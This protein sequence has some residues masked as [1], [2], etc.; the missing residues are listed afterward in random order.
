VSR[1][2]LIL[3]LAGALALAPAAASAETRIT[4]TPPPGFA[5]AVEAI[6]AKGAPGVT[7]VVMKDGRQLYRVD[8]GDIAPDAELPVASASKWM[9]AA[10][11]MSLVDDGHLAL[12]EP[13]GKRLPQFQGAAGTITL[14]QLLAQTGGMGSIVSNGLDLRQGARMTLAESAAQAAARPLEDPPGTIFKYGGPGFQVVGALAEAATGQ[15]WAD[16]FAARIARPLGLT[17]TRWTSLREPQV[18]AAETTNPL[19]QGGVVTSASDY[20]KFLTMLAG[21]G[22]FEGRQVLSRTAVEEMERLQ[23]GG[24]KMAWLPPGVD[25]GGRGIGYALGNWCEAW[26]ADGRCTLVSSPGAFGTYPWIDRKSGLYGIF[27]E[28]HRLPKVATEVK[29]ARALAM[30]A[31]RP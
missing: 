2:F 10:V 18:P 25:G 31:A 16:L 22:R 24:A 5:A 6:V 30:G 27:F 19:L 12:D 8:A 7:A 17:H 13:I 14:R 23:T 29:A 26:D 4:G 11:A 15:R 21:D 3:A 28:R 1:K 9:T 20:L